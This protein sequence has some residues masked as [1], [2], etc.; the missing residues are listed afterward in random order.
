[1]VRVWTVDEETPNETLRRRLPPRKTKPSAMSNVLLPGHVDGRSEGV[2]IH[3][4]HMSNLPRSG[5]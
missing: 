4:S 5:I 1:M 3:E 2:S